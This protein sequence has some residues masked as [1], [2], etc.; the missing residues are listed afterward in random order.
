MFKDERETVI[1]SVEESSSND[2]I[3]EDFVSRVDRTRSLILPQTHASLSLSKIKGNTSGTE[4]GYIPSHGYFLSFVE[5]ESHQLA[6][7]KRSER[8][9]SPDG[10]LTGYGGGLQL[11]DQW[12]KSVIPFNA[13]RV[14]WESLV[15]DRPN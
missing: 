5:L 13:V 15:S 3:G 6:N 9:Q 11:H 7:R 1:E 10:V 4:T 8:G 2:V 14:P 12:K